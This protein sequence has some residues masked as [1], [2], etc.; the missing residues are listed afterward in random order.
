MLPKS[1]SLRE[2]AMDG[3]RWLLRQLLISALAVSGQV[4]ESFADDFIRQPSKV[5]KSAPTTLGANVAEPARPSQAVVPNDSA[6][7]SPAPATPATTQKSS[8]SSGWVPADPKSDA[9]VAGTSNM[10]NWL[11]RNVAQAPAVEAEE[12]KPQLPTS[13]RT[14]TE[15]AAGPQSRQATAETVKGKVLDKLPAFLHLGLPEV[16]AV[17]AEQTPFDT[18]L[19]LEIP[20]QAVSARRPTQ[21]DRRQELASRISSELVSY[22]PAAAAAVTPSPVTAVSPGPGWQ[23]VGEQLADRVAKCEALLERRAYLSAKEEIEGGIVYLVRIMDHRQNRVVS[24]T[25]WAEAQQAM[26]EAD[27]FLAKERIASDPDMFNRLVQSHETPVLQ[28]VDVSNLTPIAAAQHY[29]AYAERKLIT[30]SQGHPWFSELYYCLGRTHQAQADA[31]QMPSP[32]LFEAS[33]AYYRAAFAVQPEN[34]LNANQLGY[35]LLRM[36]RPTEAFNQLIEVVRMPN[37]P[38]AAWQNVIEASNRLGNQR[39]AQWALQNYMARKDHP[40]AVDGPVGTLLEVNPQQFA[41]M[42]PY[43]SGP[44]VSAQATPPIATP[45]PQAAA[46]ASARAKSASAFRLGLFR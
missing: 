11:P 34:A 2:N 14:L 9:T 3:R 16:A 32:E 33:L 20:A 6:G 29:R 13:K 12:A 37:C 43:S 24:E 8:A 30:A 15:N 21:S 7:T 44:R 42:S 10:L 38:L 18:G 4:N 27:E 45:T 25:A 17:P 46:A 41:Q 5:T 31:G 23:A 26:R 19:E 28:G 35:V 36:D 1:Y 22:A 39:T 40:Q